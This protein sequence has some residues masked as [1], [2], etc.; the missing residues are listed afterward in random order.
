MW[1]SFIFSLFTDYKVKEAEHIHD[2]LFHQQYHFSNACSQGRKKFVIYDEDGISGW[3]DIIVFSG[4]IV[5]VYLLTDRNFVSKS[6]V[7]LE[8]LL[9]VTYGVGGIFE[10]VVSFIPWKSSI[11]LMRGP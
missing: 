1:V 10:W 3:Y 4:K 5:S 9:F 11:V 6:A 2:R 8:F 7:M